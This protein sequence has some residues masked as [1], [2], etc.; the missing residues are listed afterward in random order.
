M[1]WQAVL[2]EVIN[3]NSVTPSLFTNIKQEINEIREKPQKPKTYPLGKEYGDTYLTKR[4]AEC[5]I[6]LIQGKTIAIVAKELK[7]SP[8]TV[9]F[10]IKNI[11][12]KMRC[13]TR[14]QMIEKAL[15]SDF[16]TKIDF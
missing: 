4:E 2:N 8:R 14:M 9:E 6:Q 16:L 10:Y 13:R 11:K 7:L 1:Y 12:N 5:I 3:K 15:H